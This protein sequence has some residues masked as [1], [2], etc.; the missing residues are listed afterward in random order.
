VGEEVSSMDLNVDAF[1]ENIN[2]DLCIFIGTSGLCM[3]IREPPYY[4]AFDGDVKCA[5][6]EKRYQSLKAQM[7][8]DEA[9]RFVREFIK[10]HP[11]YLTEQVTTGGELDTE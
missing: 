6:R 10:E 8:P 5:C 11:E 7:L 4:Q 9:V 3:L 2:D 1:C